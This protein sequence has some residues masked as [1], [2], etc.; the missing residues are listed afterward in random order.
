MNVDTR[1]AI[2]PFHGAVL[3]TEQLR[4]EFLIQ[5]M[6]QPDEMTMTYSHIDRICVG[7]VLPVYG[8]VHLPDTLG[9]QFGVDFFLQRREMGIINIGGAGFVVVDGERYELAAHD[10][11]YI[12]KGAHEVTFASNDYAN[13]AKFYYSSC[14]AHHA[15]P[16]RIVTKEQSVSAEL[17]SVED[18]NRR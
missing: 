15:Y 18:C 16:T 14:P 9:R 8:V 7:G 10:G 11:L 2:H 17:G 4:Q 13:P 5:N 6:F 3:D 1:Y 12:G